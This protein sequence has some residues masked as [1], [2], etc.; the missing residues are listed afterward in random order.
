MTDRIVIVEDDMA[1]VRLLERAL[2]SSH[3][4][5][6]HY[7][8]AEAACESVRQS[9][10]ALA[11]VPADSK[12]PD[13]HST[14]RRLR[15]EHQSGIG[16]IATA[17]ARRL[18][19]LDRELGALADAFL[20]KPFMDLEHIERTVRDLA[21]FQSRRPQQEFSRRDTYFAA[22][23]ARVGSSP[24][25]AVLNPLRDAILILD[26]WGRVVLMNPAAGELLEW[27]PHATL[28]RTVGELEMEDSLRRVLAGGVARPAT[29]HL[30]DPA[31]TVQV[32]R[33]AFTP[34]PAAR[35][36]EFFVLR[37]ITAERRVEELKS[38]YLDVVSHELRTPLTALAN[39]SSLLCGAWNEAVLVRGIRQQVTRLSHQ[40]DKL[41]LLARLERGEIR[42]TAEAF[43]V[44]TAVRQVLEDCE[45]R[46]TE[47]EVRLRTE[48]P[49]TPVA[50][51]ADAEDFQ[52]ALWELLEN[53]VKFTPAGGQV[54][55][56][57]DADGTLVRVRVQDTGI[58]I[59]SG[60]HEAV[61]EEF[62]QL[63]HPLTRTYGGAGL[64]LALARRIVESWGG[65]V[66]LTSE[67]G[68]GSTFVLCIPQAVH[69][70]TPTG[71][72]PV[73]LSKPGE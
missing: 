7:G 47:H 59:D 39:F 12:L 36:G 9:P 18:R 42:D 62:R 11:I 19:S 44:G 46:A 24:A 53:A 49:E 5:I 23:H 66:E 61:F 50:G 69:T 41:I 17:E 70:K 51:L 15:D 40:V 60:D 35:G 37:D 32:T 4:E 13:S 25:S 27:E 30:K 14:L 26:E 58:G 8:D 48:L 63:E 16:I 21:G 56:S 22:D 45:Q 38:H 2:R 3:W 71:T 43:D 55:V 20:A 73:A 31:R 68:A 28:G 54:H 1:A 33:S 64:G 72:A 57:V 29:L 52:K 65:K 10:P 34:S 6:C 67:V